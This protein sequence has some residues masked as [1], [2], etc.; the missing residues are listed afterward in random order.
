[1]NPS[2]RHLFLNSI[3]SVLF[4]IHRFFILY[5]NVKLLQVPHVEVT[6]LHL[7][8]TGYNLSKYRNDYI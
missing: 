7:K 1:M 8:E 5:T 4:I 6:L 3:W 2:L